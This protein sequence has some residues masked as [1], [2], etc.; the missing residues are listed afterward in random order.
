[1]RKQWLVMTA[2]LCFSASTLAGDISGTWRTLDEET[3]KSRAD[4]VMS[5]QEDGTYSGRISVVRPLE[6]EEPVMICEKCRGDLKNAPL[7]GLEIVKGFK[8]NDKHPNEYSDGQVL[9]PKNG[10]V[11]KGKATLSDD[12]KELSMRGFIGISLLGRTTV[13]TRID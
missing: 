4:V 7:V 11:Y 12:G 1:M 3:G 2:A 5:K 6:G 9:D 8:R 10:K 13:W